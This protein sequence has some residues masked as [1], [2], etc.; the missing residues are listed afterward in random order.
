MTET[1]TIQPLGPD[2][3]LIKFTNARA[4]RFN[5]KTGKWV[6]IPADIARL[7]VNEGRAYEWVAR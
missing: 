6:R 1:Q 7:A 4:Y 5:R 2:A 3:M